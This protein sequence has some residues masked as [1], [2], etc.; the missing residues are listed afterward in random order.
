MEMKAVEELMRSPVLTVAPDLSLREAAQQ[1]N[2]AGVGCLPVVEGGRLVGIL[3]SRDL[4]GHHPNR[5][6][7]DAMSRPV[8][9]IG[10]RASLP[11]ARA[12]FT[13]YPVE[14]LVVA[15][16]GHV[17]GLLG[18][19]YLE[20]EFA[21]YLDPL[22]GLPRADLVKAQARNWL[23]Q[24]YEIAAVFL[25]MD[26]F[27]SVNKLYGHLVGDRVLREATAILQ[28]AVDPGLDLLGRYGG[29][30]FLIIT[31]RPAPEALALAHRLASDLAEGLRVGE[32]TVTVS[33]G[34]AGGKRHGER[35]GSAPTHTLDDLINLAS[36]R[37]TRAKK[38]GLSVVGEVAAAPQPA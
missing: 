36:L 23:E 1:M 21:R 19:A 38:D 29:D 16:E 33:V 22:T 9:T 7:A 26:S 35:P 28:A 25:D 2:S 14:Q 15:E 13:R 11:E 27:G 10:P 6:V 37:S 5:L 4:R 3:T 34:V 12:L 32:L 24:G 31:H 17:L 30:E 8:I 20:A 18:R